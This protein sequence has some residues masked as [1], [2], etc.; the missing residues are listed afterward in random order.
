[1]QTLTGE[2]VCYLTTPSRDHKTREWIGCRLDC[3]P[4]LL[5]R[6]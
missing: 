1:L 3:W 4:Q 6:R 2:Q 5:E